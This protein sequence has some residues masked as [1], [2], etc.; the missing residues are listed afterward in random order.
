MN[1]KQVEFYSPFA[2]IPGRYEWCRIH[3]PS[4]GSFDTFI[5]IHTTT[6]QP[7]TVYVNDL[8]GQSFM[9]DRFPES[10]CVLVKP[11]DLV[12]MTSSEGKYLW[13]KLISDKGPV[14]KA[15]MNFTIDLDSPVVEQ[16]Y[17]SEAFMVWGSQWTC[18]GI[19]MEQQAHVL[20][21]VEE[22]KGLISLDCEGILTAGS[23]GL[24]Q[25][26]G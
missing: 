3:S 20:G 4:H 7:V 26:K 5:Y 21:W 13:G 16:D 18:T 2:H 22:E 17:G 6:D 19:D 10:D 23:Q 24:I 8:K 11:E 12:I 14:K 25:K 15:M 1:T 9:R